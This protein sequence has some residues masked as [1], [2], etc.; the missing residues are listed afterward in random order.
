MPLTDI[1]NRVYNHGWQLDPVVRSLLDTAFIS[2]SC[3]YGKQRMFTPD[4]IAWLAEFQL[5]DYDLRTKDG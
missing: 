5:L 1:A 2:C 3:F 4:F